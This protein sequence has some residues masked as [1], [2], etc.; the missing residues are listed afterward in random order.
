MIPVYFVGIVIKVGGLIGNGY[1]VLGTCQSLNL[2]KSSTVYEIPLAPLEKGDL[3]PVH[4]VSVVLDFGG[5]TGIGYL[6]LST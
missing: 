3:I 5:L 6:V 2:T 1:M 4:L